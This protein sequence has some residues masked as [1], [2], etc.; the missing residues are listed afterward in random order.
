MKEAV[1]KYLLIIA[2]VAAVVRFV[3]GTRGEDTQHLHND[4]HQQIFNVSVTPV[5]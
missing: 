1:T 2:A 3:Y 5:R 4:T